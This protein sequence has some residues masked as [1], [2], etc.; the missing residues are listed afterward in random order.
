LAGAPETDFLARRFARPLG[1]GFSDTKQGKGS[2]AI[3]TDL[4]AST[5]LTERRGLL[6]DLHVNATPQQAKSGH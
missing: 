2:R 3:G 5:H 4:D 1:D 6:V